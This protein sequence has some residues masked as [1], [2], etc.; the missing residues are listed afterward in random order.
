MTPAASRLTAI[1]VEQK[2][3]RATKNPAA[4]A[5]LDLQRIGYRIS[6][7]NTR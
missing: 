6:V 5:D 3:D 7:N 2:G 1:S 4:R